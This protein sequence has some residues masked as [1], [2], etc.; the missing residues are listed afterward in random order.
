MPEEEEEEEEEENDKERQ[1]DDAHRVR[2]G[3]DTRARFGGV[4]DG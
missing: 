1:R 2:R 4:R 3:D